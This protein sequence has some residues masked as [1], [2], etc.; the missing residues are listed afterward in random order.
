MNKLIF[1]IAALSIATFISFSLRAQ[2]ST[3]PVTSGAKA[4]SA[5][6]SKPAQTTASKSATSESTMKKEDFEKRLNQLQPR[7][8]DYNTKAKEN[9]SKNPEF[10]GEVNKLN[11]M[12]SSF[13]SKVAKYDSQPKDQ[14]QAY[15][16]TL[17]Q[18]WHS[19]K[20]QQ[21]KVEQMSRKINPEAKSSAAKPANSK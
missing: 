4:T 16:E 15:S 8:N 14:Q 17:H 2:T 7:L 13:K 1:K 18:D 6:Q 5:T 21:E 12:V 10:S 19:I 3:I 11:S 9:A 20:A